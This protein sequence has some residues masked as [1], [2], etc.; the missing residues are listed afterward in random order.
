MPKNNTSNFTIYDKEYFSSAQVNLYLGDVLIDELTSINV[1]VQDSKTPIYGYASRSYDAVMNGT[2]LVQGS[3]SI[4]FKEKAYLFAVLRRLQ[5][6]KANRPGIYSSPFVSNKNV[7]FSSSRGARN[8]NEVG[9]LTMQNI[10]EILNIDENIRLG[11]TTREEEQ[12]FIRAIAAMN[13]TNTGFTRTIT[14]TGPAE[15]EFEKL[16]DRI[17]GQN[18]QLNQETDVLRS[19]FNNFT[20]YITFGDYNTNNSVNHTARRLDGV[21]LTGLQTEVNNKLSGEPIEEIYSFFAKS[22]I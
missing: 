9:G 1:R 5:Q 10:E 14:P 17:W 13:T 22:F 8:N 16:E 6:F 11:R 21:C 2:V 4:N 7:G 19:I 18:Q 15:K 20:I 3:L 12:K